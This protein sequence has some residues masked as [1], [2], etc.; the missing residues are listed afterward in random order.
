MIARTL[1]DP[2]KKIESVAYFITYL[3]ILRLFSRIDTAILA[4]ANLKQPPEHLQA[5]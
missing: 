2:W 3:Y 1:S 4:S 5:W